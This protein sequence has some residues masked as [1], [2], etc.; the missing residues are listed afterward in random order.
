MNG[1]WDLALLKLMGPKHI[2]TAKESFVFLRTPDSRTEDLDIA[3]QATCYRLGSQEA[4]K[5]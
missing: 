2:V 3:F 1:K 5:T 4:K